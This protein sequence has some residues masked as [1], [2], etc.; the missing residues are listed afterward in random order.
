MRWLDALLDTD[1]STTM[2]GTFE[3]A[4]ASEASEAA[5]APAP[6]AASASDLPPAPQDILKSAPFLALTPE[7]RAVASTLTRVTARPYDVIEWY[8]AFCYAGFS[9]AEA[10]ARAIEAVKPYVHGDLRPRGYGTSS[11]YEAP[12]DRAWARSPQ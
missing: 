9:T 4:A 1:T 6:E 10:G 11:S 8:R 5:P 12:S 2:D 3:A 7:Q